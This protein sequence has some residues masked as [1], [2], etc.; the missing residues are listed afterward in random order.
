MHAKRHMHASVYPLDFNE[1]LEIFK[2][3]SNSATIH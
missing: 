2:E 1:M 3:S